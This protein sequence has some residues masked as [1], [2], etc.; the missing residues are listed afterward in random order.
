MFAGRARHEIECDAQCRPLVLE[1]L[2]DTVSM[3]DVAA[4]KLDC[5]LSSQVCSEADVAKVILCRFVL[6]HAL[7]LEAGQTFFLVSDAAALVFALVVDLGA[8]C[9]LLGDD[10]WDLLYD[11]DYSPWSTGL[12]CHTFVE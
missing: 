10:S 3:E 11:L 7:R 6:F 8:W 2:S 4:L 9:D 12:D 5:R 1:E